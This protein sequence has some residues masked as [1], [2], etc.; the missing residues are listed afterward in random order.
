MN[1]IRITGHI[2]IDNALRYDEDNAIPIC[3]KCH[4][5]H[6]CTD[7]PDIHDRIRDIM[8]EKW[9]KTLRVKKR[10]IIKSNRAFYEEAINKYKQ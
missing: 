9:L 5:M 8:G 3:Q 6:H 2:E 1:K 4:F 7:N 10:Q